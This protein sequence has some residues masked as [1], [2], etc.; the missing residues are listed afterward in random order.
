MKNNSL[1]MKNKK[2]TRKRR[3]KN[4]V[5][6]MAL[7]HF[8]ANLRGWLRRIIKSKMILKRAIQLSSLMKNHQGKM[9]SLLKANCLLLFSQNRYWV[10]K[11]PKKCQVIKK[12]L[13][14]KVMVLKG[15]L[16][17]GRRF[18]TLLYLKLCQINYLIT[19]M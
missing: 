10:R 15:L 1:R 17:R 13:R 18:M 19:L 3:I 4:K 8:L 12:V 2:R 5:F 6:L 16:R 9:E 7:D 11:A 14:N